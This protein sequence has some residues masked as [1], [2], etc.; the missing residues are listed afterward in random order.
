MV[1]NAGPSTAVDQAVTRPVPLADSPDWTAVT[2][3]PGSSVAAA[4]GGNIPST[5][6]GRQVVYT[7]T[8]TVSPSATGMLSN[9]VIVIAATDTNPGNNT[10]TDTDTLTPQNAVA[11]P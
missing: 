7:A 10:A 8:A 3:S 1:S 5:G 2:A 11:C 4:S 6:A 9:T